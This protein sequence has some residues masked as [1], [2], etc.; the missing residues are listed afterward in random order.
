MPVRM[1]SKCSGLKWNRSRK[2]KN[3]S[4]IILIEL[5][6]RKTTWNL[7]QACHFPLVPPKPT[8]AFIH[9]RSTFMA[10]HSTIKMSQIFFNNCLLHFAN[11]NY[12]WY[13]QQ[14]CV[15]FFRDERCC[16]VV[17]PVSPDFDCPVCELKSMRICKTK[18]MKPIRLEKDRMNAI[19]FVCCQ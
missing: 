2:K 3:R 13:K 7:A 6:Q 19:S 4:S 15:T 1:R 14:S 5:H 8:C 10:I 12:L 11:V 9:R 18:R 17:R 16:L